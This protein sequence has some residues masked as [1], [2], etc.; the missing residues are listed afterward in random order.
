M[1]TPTQAEIEEQAKFA[2]QE[3]MDGS[4]AEISDAFIKIKFQLG[5]VKEFGLN[6]CQIEQVIKILINRLQGFQRGQFKCKT[7][8]ET[9]GHLQLALAF[10]ESRTKD[11]EKRGVEGTNQE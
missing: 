2:A 5:P 1:A 7:N 4:P 11:R 10:L 3:K 9:I 6:G 8:H